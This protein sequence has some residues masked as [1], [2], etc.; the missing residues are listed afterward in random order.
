[1]ENSIENTKNNEM[2]KNPQPGDDVQLNIETVTPDTEKMVVPT[3]TSNSQE[4][5]NDQTQ[6]ATAEDKSGSAELSDQETP[7]E[8]D[9]SE[10]SQNQEQTSE[11]AEGSEVQENKEDGDDERDRVETVSP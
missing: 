3:P 6:E 4:L 2:P 8:E 1:M 10:E 5:D 9:S 11:S 7:V